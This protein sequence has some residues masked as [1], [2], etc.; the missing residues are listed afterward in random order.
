MPMAKRGSPLR[1][2][3]E[4][5]ERELIEQALE[6]ADGNRVHAARLLGIS[7]RWL[8]KKLERYGGK[9]EEAAES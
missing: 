6:R 1:D 2:A 8:Q 4:R 5:Y 3:L 9:V 7:R